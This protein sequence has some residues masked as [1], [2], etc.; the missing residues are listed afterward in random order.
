MTA[1][2]F[3]VPLISL[4]ALGLGAC[5]AAGQ[6]P[7]LGM[8]NSDGAGAANGVHQGSDRLD[9]PPSASTPGVGDMPANGG[10][11]SAPGGGAGSAG[12]SCTCG[13]RVPGVDVVQG[14][15]GIQVIVDVPGGGSMIITTIDGHVE[16]Q[17]GGVDISGDVDVDLGGRDTIALGD[18]NL[19][20]DAGVGGG[21]P[22][23]S[24]NATISGSL[25]GPACGCDDQLL[26]ATIS[27]DADVGLDLEGG[28]D[29]NGLALGMNVSLPQLMLDGSSLAQASGELTID[30]AQLMLE[31]DGSHD[32][33]MISGDLG[34]TDTPWIS[35]VP[36]D[37][38]GNLD[39]VAKL[40]DQQ[41]V[42]VELTGA[43]TLK[44]SSLWCGLTPLTSVKL[45]DAK[46]TLDDSGTTVGAT[47]NV[48]LL[49]DYSL[50]GTARINA[51]FGPRDWS[52]NVCG[53]VMTKLAGSSAQAATCLDLTQTGVKQCPGK[54]PN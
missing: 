8:G 12:S 54:D 10:S 18:A 32:A 27:L 28:D 30:D 45:N 9:L 40:V 25:L 6:S 23:L 15:A 22:K 29:A 39:C 52:I 38:R 16:T 11:G 7:P 13:I 2:G 53:A 21:L 3:R 51:S 19:H 46:V 34:G 50:Q 36:L 5:S 48:S 31:T 43:L 26:P 17:E 49:A 33:L 35:D 44:G 14:D 41:L 42:S 20:L 1:L 4:I 47:S 24:G 37:A